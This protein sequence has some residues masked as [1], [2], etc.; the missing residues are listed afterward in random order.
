MFY[1]C[2]LLDK[3]GYYY[4]SITRFD[5]FISILNKMIVIKFENKEEIYLSIIKS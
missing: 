1:F 5:T 3:N 4:H 2:E